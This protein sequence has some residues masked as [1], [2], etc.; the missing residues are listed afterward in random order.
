VTFEEFSAYHVPA[1]EAAG[2][3]RHN[4]MLAILGG[5]ARAAPEH[6]WSLGAPGACAIKTPGRP[7]LLGALDEGACARFADTVRDLAYPG[8]SGPD[9]TALWFARRAE[10]HGISFRE[11]LPMQVMA[12]GARPRFPG[13]A[14]E[15]RPVTAADAPLFAE[16]LA[17]FA[18]EA[19]PHDPPATREALEKSAANG[20]HLFW[21]VDGAPVSVAGIGRRTRNAAV[22]NGV[23]TP[24]A[25]RGRGYAGSVVAAL[26]E[27]GYAEGKTSA[28][29]FVDRR[30]PASNRCYAKLGFAPVCEAWQCVRAP[31]G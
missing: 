17:A 13:A 15:A 20:N 19:T 28:C 14:G 8:V 18:R 29:L 3:A 11:R 7:I 27:K 16:W 31:P 23:Y 24:P 4:V 21:T 5:T 12:L 26:V 2:E 22:I 25:L 1:L 30:N 6:Y 10:T 9:S